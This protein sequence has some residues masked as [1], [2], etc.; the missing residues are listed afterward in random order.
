MKKSK[1]RAGGGKRINCIE[2]KLLYLIVLLM[3]YCSARLF[4]M[5]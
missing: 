4:L 2:F 3:A 1:Q 5:R